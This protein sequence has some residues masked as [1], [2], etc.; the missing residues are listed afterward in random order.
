MANANTRD[1]DFARVVLLAIRS[2]VRTFDRTCA[3]L[4]TLVKI[5]KNARDFSDGVVCSKA[6]LATGRWHCNRTHPLNGSARAGHYAKFKH[7]ELQI[8]L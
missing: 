4:D 6:T 5:D 2:R 1:S 3:N 7:E 8:E